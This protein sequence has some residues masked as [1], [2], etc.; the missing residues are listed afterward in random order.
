MGL[1]VNH[2]LDYVILTQ[3]GIDVIALGSFD[4]R[5]ITGKDGQERVIHCLEQINYL[6]VDPDNLI[7]FE[8]LDNEI[9]IHVK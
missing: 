3:N 5:I 7:E 6:K 1:L 8:S 9:A 4:K 2:S